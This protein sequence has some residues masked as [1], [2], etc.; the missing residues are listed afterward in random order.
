MTRGPAPAS[1]GAARTACARV[2]V[3]GGTGE[4]TGEALSA[5]AVAERVAWCAALVQGMAGRL[6]AARWNPADLTALASGRDAADRPLPAQRHPRLRRQ[7]PSPP[8]LPRGK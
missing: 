3:R 8:V 5:A 4:E 2:L 1:G 7:R 6:V